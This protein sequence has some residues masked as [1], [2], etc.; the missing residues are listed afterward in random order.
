[1]AAWVGMKSRGASPV[2]PTARLPRMA[3]TQAPAAVSITKQPSKYFLKLVSSL[4]PKSAFSS[5]LTSPTFVEAFQLTKISAAPSGE[6]CTSFQVFVT[7]GVSSLDVQCSALP[8][9]ALKVS[10]A[11]RSLSAKHAWSQRRYLPFAIQPKRQSLVHF[12]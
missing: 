10:L 11:S 12:G 6:L 8:P 9:P 1:M 2:S 5:T 3:P 7:R 4:A